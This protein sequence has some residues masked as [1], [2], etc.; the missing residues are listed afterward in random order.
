MLPI[1]RDAI[2]LRYQLIP[3]LYNLS[4][5]SALS[6]T[7]I[8][9]PL[10]YHYPNDENVYESSFE[11]LVGRDV[12][13]ASVVE[14]SDERTF[15]LPQNPNGD[16]QWCSLWSG[17][18]VEGGRT[19]SLYI[20]LEQHGAVFV[21]QGAMIPTMKLMPFVG[22]EPDSER[23]IWL[24]PP[25]N[26]SH[27][28]TFIL[29]EDDGLSLHSPCTRILIR[30][31]STPSSVTVEAKFLQND[32]KVAYDALSFTLPLYDPRPVP[33]RIYLCDILL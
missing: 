13:V 2:H 22:S 32:Y 26:K 8:I 14:E 1:I 18:W 16:E 30:M 12:F 10:I 21:R 6:G 19:Q 28:S 27:S 5:E 33:S 29:H 31:E 9:R 15:Y 24:F 3:Y 17:D 11:F 20:P 25:N 4:V 7:P 23:T